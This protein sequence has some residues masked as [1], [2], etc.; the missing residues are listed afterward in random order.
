MTFQI[1]IHAP[2]RG[3]RLMR[4]SRRA[5]LTFQS[6]PPC[7]GDSSGSR[8]SGARRHFNP[9]PLAGATQRCRET[10]AVSEI[11]IHAPLRG[12]LAEEG[13]NFTAVKFQSTPPCG[14]DD[15]DE[16]ALLEF[17]ISIHAPLRGRPRFGKN[18]QT[19]INFNPRPLAGATAS[20][21]IPCPATLF[22]ST[23]PCGGDA[24]G[25]VSLTNNLISIHAPL[26]G[27]PVSC[28]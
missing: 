28:L 5:R 3:R 8:S 7:G 25:P 4:Y 21:G 11:S 2:L 13:F 20:A 24:H 16:A 1:S 10:V 6:T 26:R 22:Q 27:R 19:G 12:R 9:R 17:A 18:L 23:P 15:R 14:G